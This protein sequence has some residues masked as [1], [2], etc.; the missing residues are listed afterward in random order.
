VQNVATTLSITTLSIMEL[1]LQNKHST[2]ILRVTFLLSMK[3]VFMMN[4]TAM[5]SIKKKA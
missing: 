5:L 2:F 3:K 1:M 4:V